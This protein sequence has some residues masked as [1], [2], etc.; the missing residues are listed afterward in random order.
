MNKTI[1]IVVSPSGETKVETKGFAGTECREASKFVEQ[2][3]GRR[4]NEQLTAEFHQCSS[5][6]ETQQ[7]TGR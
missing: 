7:Q 1:E 3:L 4:V 2:A 6:Q 5:Q